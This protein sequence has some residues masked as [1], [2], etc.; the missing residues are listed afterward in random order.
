MHT[1]ILLND[2]FLIIFI[3]VHQLLLIFFFLRNPEKMLIKLCK[4]FKDSSFSLIFLMI[5]SGI[6]SCIDDSHDKRGIISMAN[7]GPNTNTS[8]FYITYS[9]INKLNKKYPVFG[10]VIDGF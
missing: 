7:G 4:L 5:L 3:Y 8:Q 2:S 10:K 1:N 6:D 9:A